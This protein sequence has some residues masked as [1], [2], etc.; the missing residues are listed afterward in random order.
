MDIVY[1]LRI[2]SLVLLYDFIDDQLGIISH[3]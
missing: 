2:F 3:L 1:E